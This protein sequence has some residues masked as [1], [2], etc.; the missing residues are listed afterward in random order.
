MV[1]LILK[2]D[3]YKSGELPKQIWKECEIT[4]NKQEKKGKFALPTLLAKY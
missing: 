4:A 3:W 1:H 2:T